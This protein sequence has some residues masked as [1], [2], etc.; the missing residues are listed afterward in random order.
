LAARFPITA[1]T[2]V[3][4]VSTRKIVTVYPDEPATSVRRLLREY[5]TRLALVIDRN[6]RLLGIVTR[7]NILV[8]SSRKSNARARD[9]M[10]TP[11]FTFD[12]DTLISNAVK[13]MLKA[14]EWY[15]PVLD[16]GKVYGVFGL[17]HAIQRMLDENDELLD[18]ISVSEI[19]TTE[20]ETVRP[21]DY[22]SS[23]WDKMIELRYAGLPVTDDK[24]RLVGIITQ[25]DLL[26]GGV[27]LAREAVGGPSRG[28]RIREYMTSAVEFVTTQDSVGKAARLIVNR[29]YGRIPV[30][31]D[32]K[33]RKLVGIVDR[34]DVV[35]LLF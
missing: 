10:E 16:N 2:P 8:I 7:G 18:N 34:E 14:D 12:K 13:R 23:V 27:V 30:V 9:L 31:S 3:G 1:E 21:D 25:Y 17:E 4:L 6:E 24:G 29:G 28:G 20:I 35:K 32:K 33:S 22:L 26:A 19:M 5:K 11:V 15:V